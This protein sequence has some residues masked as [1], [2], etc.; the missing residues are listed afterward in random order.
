MTQPF[1]APERLL[2]GPGPSNVAPEVLAASA[3]TTIGHL[4]PAFQAM[5]E[6]VKDLLRYAFQTK[7]AVTFPISAPASLAMESGLVNVLEPGDTAIIA[8]NGVFGGRMADIVGRCGA[9]CVLVETDWGKPVDLDKVAEAIKAHPEAKLLGFVHA[10]TSTGAESDAA[11]LAKMASDAGMLSLMDTVTG[12]GGVPVRVDDWGVDITYSGTQK[13]LSVP[14]GLAPFTLSERAIEAVEARKTKVQSWFND[15]NLVLGYWKSGGGGARSYHHTAPVN[16]LYGL[17]EGLRRLQE[18]GLEAAWA[19]HAAAHEQLAKGLQGLELSFVVDAPYR[20]PQLNSVWVPE[21]VDDAAT[22]AT[23]LN[24]H[25]IEIGAGLGP[26]AG[27]VWRIGLMG[28]TAREENVGRLLGALSK[29][30][31]RGLQAAE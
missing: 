24:D 1:K 28:E 3:Q 4:D 22:R 7:N 13:C 31:G 8:Q 14:P 19:R 5:M 23:L 27:K 17:H 30:L 10:E 16:A 2:M 12:L 6:E 25:G 29:V 11:S 9:T 18:E 21:G 15:L 20:L 26:F